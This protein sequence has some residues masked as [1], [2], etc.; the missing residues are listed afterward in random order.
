MSARNVDVCRTGAGVDESWNNNKTSCV[1]E[2]ALA[3]A[4]ETEVA[5]AA[6]VGAESAGCEKWDCAAGSNAR[7]YPRVLDSVAHSE[8]STKPDSTAPP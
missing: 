8:S 2:F 3:I 7:E 6:G 1:V 4:A 5:C